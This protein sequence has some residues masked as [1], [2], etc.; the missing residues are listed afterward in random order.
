MTTVIKR[1]I[2]NTFETPILLICYNRDQYIREQIYQIK[3]IKPK[4]VFIACDGPKNSNDAI[5]VERVRQLYLELID[6]DCDVK[7]LFSSSNQGC[8]KGVKSALTWFFTSNKEGIVLEDDII[9]SQDFFYFMEVML[10]N[11][12]KDHNIF[13]LS[14]CNLGYQTELS[15]F[16]SKIMNM[17]GWAT[18]A[19]RFFEVDFSISSWQE[20]SNKRLYLFKKLRYH[21]FDYDH[22]WIEY[23]I[24]IFDSAVNND[25]F[26]TWDYQLIYNQITSEKIC[27]YP[28]KNLI[29]NLGFHEDA[30]HTKLENHAAKNLRVQKLDW[31]LELPEHIILDCTF[32]EKYIKERWAYYKRPNW[33]Y[34]L[35]NI[36][37][38]LRLT[39]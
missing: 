39:N 37:K 20:V 9:P 35:G 12:R 38:K 5:K 30:T 4:N 16:G 24:S 28:G 32:Y 31:P 34:Y 14:G 6:W 22:N 7:T 27:I 23:W 15:I 17:W 10:K 29:Q 3:Q 21:I 13:C 26:S 33:K 19:D 11:Y 36:L 1:P 25:D 2:N 8:F 18:W